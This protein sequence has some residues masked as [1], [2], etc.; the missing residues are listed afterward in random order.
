MN[1]IPGAGTASPTSEP[2]LDHAAFLR[3]APLRQAMDVERAPRYSLEAYH[4][5]GEALKT[6]ARLAPHRDAIAQMPGFDM[7]YLDGYEDLARALRCAQVE[8]DLRVK[9]RSNVPKLTEEGYPLRGMMLAYAETLTFKGIVSTEVV[10]QVREGSGTRDLGRDLNTLATLLLKLPPV[11]L[12]DHTPVTKA[13]AERGAEIANQIFLQVGEG[14]MLDMPSEALMKER[15]K[16]GGLLLESQGQLRRVVSYLRYAEGDAATIVPS[17]FVPGGRPPGKSQDAE[18]VP[19]A[20]VELATL[21][22]RLHHPPG[23][24]AEVHPDDNPFHEA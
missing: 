4:A 24:P 22:E 16:L 2:A 23:T 20:E 10:A 6:V 19:D 13:E 3:T 5:A 18:P 12:T 14:A 11:Y 17:L 15:Q 1:K 8:L 21:H 7:A 9:G